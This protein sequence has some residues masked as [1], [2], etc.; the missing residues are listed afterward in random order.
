MKG[1]DNLYSTVLRQL[2]EAAEQMNLDP[3]IHTILR[4]PKRSLIVCDPKKFS[5]SEIER[6]TRRYATEIISIIGPEKDIPAP[7]INT[8]SQIMAWIMDTYSMDKGYS[9]P[10]VVTGKPVS[11]GGS[12]GRDV[13]TSRGVMYTI[14]NTA[15]TLV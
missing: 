15:K 1:R 11:I 5:S 7:D 3:D 9:V 8:N 12:Q 14:F 2:D 10:G 13:A 4:Y 6:L